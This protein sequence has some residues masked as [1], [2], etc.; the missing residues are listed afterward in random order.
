MSKGLLFGVYFSLPILLVEELCLNLAG[1]ILRRK[2][3]S[4]KTDTIKAIFTYGRQSTPIIK[5]VW[6]NGIEK[7]IKG[8]MIIK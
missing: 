2:F 8:F 6:L 1:G 4:T 5:A 7:D 3:G